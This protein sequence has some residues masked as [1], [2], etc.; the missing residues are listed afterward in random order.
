MYSQCIYTGLSLQRSTGDPASRLTNRV[1][2]LNENAI[3][4]DM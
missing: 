3:A 1:A 4:D 2:F